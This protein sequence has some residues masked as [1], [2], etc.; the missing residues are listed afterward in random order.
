MPRTKRT[1]VPP[2]DGGPEN[3]KGTRDDQKEATLKSAVVILAALRE[4][5]LP[6][7]KD[8]WEAAIAIADPGGASWRATYRP[9]VSHLFEEWRSP[10]ATGG[11]TAKQAAK[12]RDERDRALRCVKER[13]VEI[14]GLR[15]RIGEL[16]AE[17]AKL[18]RGTKA[19]RRRR[20]RQN[21]QS[22]TDETGS[23]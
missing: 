12:L 8:G 3:L 17:N 23:D 2:G 7:T 15:A 5:E 10:T 13:D 6:F 21:R 18:G 9:H 20:P 16:E 1:R 22:G 11:L 4:H 14:A 19:R